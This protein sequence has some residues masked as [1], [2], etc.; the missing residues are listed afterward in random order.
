MISATENEKIEVSLN[1][2]NKTSWK[3]KIQE[4]NKYSNVHIIRVLEGKV[5]KDSVEEVSK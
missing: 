1:D 2:I 5:R 4:S 3:T